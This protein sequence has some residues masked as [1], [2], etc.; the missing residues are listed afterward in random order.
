MSKEENNKAIVGRWFTDFWGKVLW[1][2]E[3]RPKRA[4]HPRLCRHPHP[5]K[6][7]NSSRQPMKS[8]SK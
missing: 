4:R 6:T 3:S 8:W 7:R 5:I 1:G 2:V